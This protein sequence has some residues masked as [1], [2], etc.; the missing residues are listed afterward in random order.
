MSEK[1]IAIVYGS[2]ASMPMEY[3]TAEEKGIF[4][5]PFKIIPDNDKSLEFLDTPDVDKQDR[6][7]FI[8]YVKSPDHRVY[9][10]QPN[11]EDYIARFKKAEEWGADE[12]IIPAI[13]PSTLSGAANSVNNAIEEYKATSDI[14][15]YTPDTISKVSLAEGIDVIKAI[16]LREQGKASEDILHSIKDSYYDCEMA[17]VI[18][19]LEPLKKSGRI[20]KAAGYIAGVF[21]IKAVVS[22]D[23]E[24]GELYGIAKA[25]G[26]EKYSKVIAKHLVSKMGNGA[27]KLT[28]A[29]FELQEI[30]LHKIIERTKNTLN[31]DIS[32][33]VKRVEQSYVISAYTSVDSAGI[34][35]EKI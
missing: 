6:D 27:V 14:P 2:S 20:G 25:R 4:E 30:D 7:R 19:D 29:Y 32:S 17:Q 21:D 10:S 34:F 23:L 22:L 11:S 18:S 31:V 28:A 5:V 8:E 33:E 24:A 16:D 13:I 35:A 9:T 1:K 3:R 12:I 26:S 15:V